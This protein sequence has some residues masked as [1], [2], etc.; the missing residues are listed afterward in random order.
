M[1][2]LPLTSA[3]VVAGVVLIWL[4]VQT[5]VT[6]AETS[7]EAG[8]SADGV[9][10]WL[11]SSLRRVFP[12]TPPGSKELSLLVARNS[13]ASFQ[14]AL[15]TQ[16]LAKTQTACAV[17]GAD[18][19]KPRVRFVGLVPVPHHS[20]GTPVSE[21]DGLGEVP[22]LVPD[23]LMPWTKVEVGPRQSRSYWISLN[24]PA[25]AKPGP[26]ELTVRVTIASDAKDAKERVV[27]LPVKLDISP[28]V[29]Q[30]RKDFS[31]THWWWGTTTWDHYK[32]GMLEDE[33]WWQITREQMT[34]LWET[35]TTSRTCRACSCA[36]RL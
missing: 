26:R 31:V 34:N 20:P 21:L 16:D 35:A 27:E 33:K 29:V 15:R 19:L 17:A 9:P 12:D 10:V 14:V 3:R 23:P 25:D 30:P 11:E 1:T 13:R 5:S 18:D 6:A 32:T 36:A 8:A 24:I 7:R 22:G 4:F 28:L 2:R